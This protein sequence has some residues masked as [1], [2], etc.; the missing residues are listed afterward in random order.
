[1]IQKRQLSPEN[2]AAKNPFVPDHSSSGVTTTDKKTGK[3]RTS[4]LAGLDIIT[5]GPESV[6][7][8]DSKPSYEELELGLRNAAKTI[9][10]LRSRIA[11]LK[12]IDATPS[13][14]GPTEENF[15]SKF[16]PIAKVLRKV[17]RIGFKEGQQSAL[18]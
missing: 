12:A 1:M 4:S 6:L 9:K 15:Y 7:S 10:R 16:M 17:K 5:K 8:G 2:F 11:E 3:K 18:V 14:S 13:K